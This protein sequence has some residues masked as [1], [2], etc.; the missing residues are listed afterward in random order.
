[1]GAI[2]GDISLRVLVDTI[3]WRVTLFGA[4]AAGVGLALVLWLVI[5]DVNP[6]NS[7]SAQE[8]L[9]FQQLITGLWKAMCNV[10]I[11]LIGF[12]GFLLYL[13][14]SAFAE[15][16]A[17]PYL[18]QAQHLTRMQAADATSMIFLGWA[19]G[20]P[21]WGWF[22]D[23]IQ[24]RRLPMILSS[25]GALLI[26]CTLLYGPSLSLHMTYFLLFMSGLLSGVQILVFALAREVTSIKLAGTTIGLIN[27]IVMIGGNIFQPV[28]GELLDIKWD[29]VLV[30]GARIY[31][32][33][34]Y[35]YSLTVLPL[36]I[37]AAVLVLIFIKETHCKIKTDI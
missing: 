12:V 3:G 17:V 2:A 1:M 7:F 31:S 32:N 19:I 37:L 34:A 20:S 13:S 36:S 35:S 28:I 16:W 30:D 4:A 9:T 24:L 8:E 25:L 6:R 27:M 5:R 29:G 18:E 26:T 15:M 22:S 14:L 33:S 21:M 23:Y 11:W 10:Q